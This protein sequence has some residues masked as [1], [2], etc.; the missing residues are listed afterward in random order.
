VGA[1]PLDRP[2]GGRPAAQNRATDARL[3]AAA[4]FGGRVARRFR[5]KPE[6]ARYRRVYGQR[7]QTENGFSR[8][9]RVLGSTVRAARWANRKAEL[10]RR[11]LTYN[12]MPLAAA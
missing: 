2:Q 9:E 4:G 11:R 7:W 3:S 5:P 12:F 6:G 10:A 1:R 8:L